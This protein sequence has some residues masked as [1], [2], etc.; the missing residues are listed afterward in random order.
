MDKIQNVTPRKRLLV[1]VVQQTTKLIFVSLLYAQIS[2]SSLSFRCL[3]AWVSQHP[4]GSTLWLHMGGKG[5]CQHGFVILT[6]KRRSDK[7]SLSCGTSCLQVR[8]PQETWWKIFLWK[9]KFAAFILRDELLSSVS[10]WSWCCQEDCVPGF[11]AR[12]LRRKVP[13]SKAWTKV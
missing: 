12:Y 1:S 4:G 8:N 9:D 10:A 11:A 3:L 13:W 6:D 7:M 5:V 2:W